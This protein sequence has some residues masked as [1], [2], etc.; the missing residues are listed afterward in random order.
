[1]P[2]N[3]TASPSLSPKPSGTLPVG[4]MP[5]PMPM[6]KPGGRRL[7][8]ATTSSCP[9]GFYSADSGVLDPESKPA[10]GP[11][12]APKGCTACPEG[13]TTAGPGA[14]SADECSGGCFGGLFGYGVEGRGLGCSVHSMVLGAGS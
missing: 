12:P 8:Q 7:A 11:G 5:L 3:S 4:A 6:S 2:G 14:M 13:S 9:V 1:M 10:A